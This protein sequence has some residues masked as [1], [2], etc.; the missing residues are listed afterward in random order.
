MTLW[1]DV[2]T[3]PPGLMPWQ[4]RPLTWLLAGW[5]L[6]LLVLTAVFATI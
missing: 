3:K 2:R 5:G 4:K 1:T 6:L